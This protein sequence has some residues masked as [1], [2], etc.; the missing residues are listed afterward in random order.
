M[1]PRAW[2]LI[3]ALLVCSACSQGTPEP[4]GPPPPG[5][6]ESAPEAT[7]TP[8]DAIPELPPVSAPEPDAPTAEQAHPETPSEPAVPAPDPDA[9]PPSLQACALP[10]PAAPVPCESA[11]FAPIYCLNFESAEE[12]QTKGAVLDGQVDFVAGRAGHAARPMTG[13]LAIP[14]AQALRFPA[15][16]LAVWVAV[17][18]AERL[19]HEFR[20]VDADE[21]APNTWLFRIARPK[22]PTLQFFARQQGKP[23]M[24][25][26]VKTSVGE[27]TP[28]AWRHVVVSWEE[29]A[30]KG[31]L[32]L[33]LDGRLQDAATIAGELP[34]NASPPKLLYLAGSHRAGDSLAADGGLS[35]DNLRTYGRALSPEDVS[36]LYQSELD[37]G[38]PTLIAGRMEV[39]LLGPVDGF[40]VRQITDRVDGRQKLLAATPRALWQ[41]ELQAVSPGPSGVVRLGNLSLGDTL[42]QCQVAPDSGELVLAWNGLA[43]SPDNT[44]DVAMRLVPD[45][46]QG[47]VTVSLRAYHHGSAWR[48]ASATTWLSGIAP[49]QQ[50]PATTALLLTGPNIG[51]LVRD[52]FTNDPAYFPY[53]LS[54]LALETFEQFRY[55]SRF[56]PIPFTGLL[57]LDNPHGG[58]YIAAADPTFAMKAFR[59]RRAPAKKWHAFSTDRG[60]DIGLI[61]YPQGR[62]APGEMTMDAAP[63]VIGLQDGDWYQFARR[64]RAFATTLP[65]LAGKRLHE[66][67]DRPSWLE[68]AGIVQSSAYDTALQL[69]AQVK[70][71]G[72]PPGLVLWHYSRWQHANHYYEAAYP[73]VQTQTNDT[74]VTTPSK[75]F[76]GIVAKAKA[77]LVPVAPYLWPTAWDAVFDSGTTPPMAM[78]QGKLAA[79]RDPAGAIVMES[80]NPPLDTPAMVTPG[81]PTQQ[82]VKMCPAAPVW[83]STIQQAGEEII[84]S[85][86]V[87]GLYLDVLATGNPTLCFGSGPGHA[88]APGDARAHVHGYRAMLAKLRAAAR[89]KFSDAGFYSEGFSD[90][91][92]DLIDGYLTAYLPIRDAVPIA[93][94]VYHDY[95]QF[96]GREVDVNAE[97][98]AALVAKQGEL[99]AWGGMP[100]FAVGP[101]TSASNVKAFFFRN[102]LIK[103]G[104]L[105]RAFR[106]YLV[107]GEMLQPIA[108]WETPPP[109]DGQ[110]LAAAVSGTGMLQLN[111]A[112][113]DAAY[114]AANP[115]V[116]QRYVGVPAASATAWRAPSGKVGV[117]VASLE[118]AAAKPRWVAVPVDRAAWSLGGAA[119]LAQVVLGKE[120]PEPMG[121]LGS[122]VQYIV[123]KLSP[124]DVILLEITP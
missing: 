91:Y 94:A 46:A 38:G 32:R 56:L 123:L 108:L 66:R 61:S 111:L 120:A 82:L 40:G 53:G 97:S 106:S 107:F 29:Q 10:D 1:N 41:V 14:L 93:M 27:W 117:V 3:A 5:A 104:R 31:H 48:I 11:L 95:A 75:E 68:Q 28:R 83:Q 69:D 84:A 43:I 118:A 80:G 98:L 17:E 39:A 2:L 105:R 60:L 115:T 13:A 58:I 87:T 59:Y 113:Y 119:T 21:S 47:A 15:G 19:Q 103:L 4:E 36:Q 101:L 78:A 100:G 70:A 35:L 26:I 45:P 77:A 34:S 109:K 6:G 64:Y 73:G 116:T 44:L 122:A 63:L 51:S 22:E 110:L 99:F 8:P 23:P 54:A 114:L 57:D 85:P 12:L 49:P 81:Y 30:G 112:Q 90:P 7:P 121:A 18:S 9:P 86:G 50:N 33:Y 65:Y 96:L 92:L 52:P 20:L 42:P 62:T 16:T 71:A 37:G 102:Y 89:V 74:P 25:D 79:I 24:A 124:Q 88:H 67:S 72:G 55:P 76:S